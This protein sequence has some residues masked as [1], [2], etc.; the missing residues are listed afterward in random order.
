MRRKTYR[1]VPKVSQYKTI[2]KSYQSLPMRLD[3]FRQL[4]VSINHYNGTKYSVR[5]VV[6]S[7]TVRDAEYGRK[8]AIGSYTSNNV[9]D[10]GALFSSLRLHK[11][12]LLK[13][14]E[15]GNSCKNFISIF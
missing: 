7:I 8:A 13:Y 9:N 2:N 6:T 5:D 4:K 11:L 10:V 15:D 3:F 1:V 12:P 14:L